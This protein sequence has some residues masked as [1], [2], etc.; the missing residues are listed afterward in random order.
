MINFDFDY[1]EFRPIGSDCFCALRLVN[2]GC[3]FNRQGLYGLAFFRFIRYN[4]RAPEY[5][6][7]AIFGCI[8]FRHYFIPIDHT[9]GNAVVSPNRVYLMPDR[10]AVKIQFT[11]RIHKTKRHGIRIT[12]RIDDRQHARSRSAQD[13]FTRLARYLLSFTSHLIHRDFSSIKKSARRRIFCNVNLSFLR[14]DP[15]EQLVVGK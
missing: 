6:H 13:F 12:V 2:I 5:N 7:A 9:K 3:I 1:T 4:P 10:R 11:V 14:Q 8:Q 15:G